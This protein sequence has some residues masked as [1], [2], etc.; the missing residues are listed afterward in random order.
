MSP[1][2]LRRVT[3]G[4]RVLE[5][6]R[7]HAAERRCDVA[8][9]DASGDAVAATGPLASAKRTADGRA[10]DVPGTARAS[11]SPVR[12]FEDVV[13][14]VVT[15]PAGAPAPAT[16]VEDVAARS[17]DL[18][19]DLCTREFELNDLS[20]EI[21]G[22]Y[23]E[24]NLFYDLAGDLA[25][26]T[27]AV[28]ISRVVVRRASAIL[29]AESSWVLLRETGDVLRQAAVFSPP[30][31]ESEIPASAGV[32][33]RCLARNAAELLDDASTAPEG[34]LAGWEKCARGPLLTVPVGLPGRDDRPPL[35]VLQVVRAHGA[36]PFT[37][38]E[39]KLA[40]ALASHAAA[41]VENQRLI[42]YERELRLARTIQ[43][44]LLPQKAPH[45]DGLDVAG[46][47]VAAA[48]VGG[49][50]YDHIVADGGTLGVVV[51]DVS[52]HDLAAALVQS[53]A[54]T[55]IRAH[56]L[57]GGGPAA[58]LDGANRALFDDLSRADMYLTA[59]IAVVDGRTGR[60]AF[61]DAG[62]PPALVLRAATGE[63]AEIAAGGV[64]IGVLPDGSYAQDEITL[65][66]GDVLVVYTDGVTEA[67][68]PADGTEY[69]I[70]RLADVL[71][72]SAALD[73]GGIADA[74]LEDVAVWDG[75]ASAPDD[76]SLVVVK[77][78][79]PV[80]R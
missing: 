46:R 1:A 4:S 39:V 16:A 51:A 9:F 56:V 13:G 3:E 30:Q 17:A 72:R 22:S 70:P 28:A 53:A 29:H 68:A 34:S 25:E 67:R 77:M 27:D 76:R 6:L 73:A 59:W 12:V 54:R 52:G 18:L 60:V 50:Y 71:R 20:R 41:L 21:L 23:E 47:C 64:P 49:D 24:L 33:G 2:E 61:A 79:D 35:G 69:G 38:G 11:A 42:A 36:E 19:S 7:L 66:P 48:S 8:V 5:M 62:H 78:R 14:W 63:V 10:W 32:A 40:C 58:V 65:V 75:H 44:S 15:V 26:A 74:I 57:A 31:G 80:S 55:T 43:Q 45:V 37:A